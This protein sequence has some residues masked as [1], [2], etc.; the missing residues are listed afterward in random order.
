MH[1][2]GA[3]SSPN[4]CV[5]SAVPPYCLLL[6][7]FCGGLQFVYP[8]LMWQSAGVKCLMQFS[9][10]V[11]PPSSQVIKAVLK[12]VMAGVMR[13]HALGIVHRDVK[14]DNL[15]ITADGE[16]RM[17]DMVVLCCRNSFHGGAQYQSLW[18]LYITQQAMCSLSCALALLP[19]APPS[20]LGPR[21]APCVPPSSS[22]TRQLHSLLTSDAPH[23]PHTRCYCQRHDQ[24][25][26]IDFGAACDM[27]TGINFNPL[28][29]MLDPRYSPPEE[30]VMPQS[31]SQVAA[32]AAAAAAAA[33]GGVTAAAA[34][35]AAAAAVV[36]KM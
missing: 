36:G 34:T 14:P 6:Y 28:Y 4:A 3:C 15:L 7:C 21:H 27:C 10:F 2:C 18:W 1:T 35:T 30:L 11:L 5:S 22:S 19:V 32:A 23:P 33:D 26:I 12:Q 16:V 9:R 24:V 13:L 29:G 31:E 25:K 8:S 20:S 17:P